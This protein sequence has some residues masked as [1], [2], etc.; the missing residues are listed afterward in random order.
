MK[1]DITYLYDEGLQQAQAKNT[2]APKNG[3]LKKVAQNIRHAWEKLQ[4]KIHGGEVGFFDLPDQTEKVHQIEKLVTQFKQKGYSDFI[5]IGI[6][7]SS[8]GAKCILESVHDRADGLSPRFHFLDN[9]DPD[10]LSSVLYKI[11]LKHSLFF[12]VTKSGGTMETLG[13]LMG[14]V[15]ALKEAGI[16]E[17]AWKNHLV[18][19]TDP[20]KGDLRKFAHRL[21]LEILDIPSNVGGRFSALTPVGLFPAQMAGIDC[22]E[23]M[24]GALQVRS[25]CMMN[26]IEQNPVL[27]LGGLLYL[28]AK[29]FQRNQTVLMPYS[30]FMREFAHWF[31]QL[32][33]ESLGKKGQGLSPVDSIGATDQ[34]SQLQ[35]FSE[36]ADERVLGFIDIENYASDT[37][38]GEEE[39]N[40]SLFDNLEAFK[41]LSGSS[42]SKLIKAE[43]AGTQD[44]LAHRGRPSFRI[45]IPDRSPSSIGQCLFFFETLTAFTGFLFEINPFDQPGVE[46]SKKLALQYLQQ[47]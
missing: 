23:L 6:G 20:E 22:R 33:A 16:E 17:A 32:W 31:V 12:V 38:L 36:G 34:H 18:V 43:S 13:N 26:Q 30:S 9:S 19:S 40:S 27:Q 25:S 41:R 8:L 7:G 5:Q 14:V 39:L 15:S 3:D 28:H 29:E 44:A 45:Q 21:G 10:L 24:K 35:L 47:S 1:L 11:D 4:E 2:R 42:L 46:E 37:K